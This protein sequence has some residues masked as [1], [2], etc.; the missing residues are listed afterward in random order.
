MSKTQ[1]LELK[2]DNIYKKIL[3]N[4]YPKDLSRIDSI[5]FIE[6]MIA[7]QGEFN[8]KFSVQEFMNLK[9]VQHIHEI[10]SK[11]LVS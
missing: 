6:L 11:K 7:I 4:P 8:I 9:D 5:V 3:G 10:V 2:L 1:Q